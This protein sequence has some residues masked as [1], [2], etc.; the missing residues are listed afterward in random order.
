MVLLLDDGGAS[1]VS[2][3]GAA[4]ALTALDL[5]SCEIDEAV[6]AALV[7]AAQ[8]AL[9]LRLDGQGRQSRGAL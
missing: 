8:P 1:L 4:P 3:L 7:K 5:R 9:E 6:E 2:A